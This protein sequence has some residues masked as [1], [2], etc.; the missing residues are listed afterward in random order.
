MCQVSS[1]LLNTCWLCRALD[2]LQLSSR[3]QQCVR[4]GLQPPAHPEKRTA[5]WLKRHNHRLLA[6]APC[7]LMQ[8]TDADAPALPTASDKY[9][10][11]SQSPAPLQEG[12][13]PLI[14]EMRSAK[15]PK[16]AVMA[17]K[18]S[19]TKTGQRKLVPLPR[20]PQATVG[21]EGS[22]QQADCEPQVA[23]PSPAAVEPVNTKPEVMH[24]CCLCAWCICQAHTVHRLFHTDSSH[25]Q[26]SA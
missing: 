5:P 14:R 16:A 26:I 24:L 15:H 11:S 21:M 22:A 1:Q 7:L 13:A 3:H 25:V 12:T 20:K 2:L 6:Y 17:V 18:P 4:S 23:T 9:P 19:K 10:I 8:G